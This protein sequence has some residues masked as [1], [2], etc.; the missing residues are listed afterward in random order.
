VSASR[1]LDGCGPFSCA[2]LKLSKNCV[3]PFSLQINPSFFLW[4]RIAKV[5]PFWKLAIKKFNYF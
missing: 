3:L 5:R 4:K 1:L 2:G